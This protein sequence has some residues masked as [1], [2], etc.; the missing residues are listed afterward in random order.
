MWVGWD[1][2]LVRVGVR[3]G[4]GMSFMARARVRFG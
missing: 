4:V 2:F 1:G 3:V